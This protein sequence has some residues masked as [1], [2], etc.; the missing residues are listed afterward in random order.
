MTTLAPRAES[1]RAMAAPIPEEE[2]LMMATLSLRVCGVVV[3][4][5]VDGGCWLSWSLSWARRVVGDI[6]DSRCGMVSLMK[7]CLCQE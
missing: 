1:S 2:P 4:V 6:F 5:V 7:E 3:I